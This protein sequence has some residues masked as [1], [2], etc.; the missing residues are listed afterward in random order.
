MP[1]QRMKCL[2]SSW[3][4]SPTRLPSIYRGGCQ[5]LV[6]VT[7]FERHDSLLPSLQVPQLDHPVGVPGFQQLRVLQRYVL[8]VA[9]GTRYPGRC[10]TRSAQEMTSVFRTFR[11]SLVKACGLYFLELRVCPFAGLSLPTPGCCHTRATRRDRTETIKNLG[12]AHSP[13]V[14]T[15][16]FHRL[17]Q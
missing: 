5:S 2:A 1:E 8:P 12:R 16:A 9:I 3:G 7:R 4:G 14:T 17:Q 13:T 15:L 6:L 10:R 11:E